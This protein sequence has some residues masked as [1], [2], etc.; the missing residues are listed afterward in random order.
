MK[1]IP[2]I[3]D[4]TNSNLIRNLN[5][6]KINYANTRCKFL[7]YFM[8]QNSEA[9]GEILINFIKLILKFCMPENIKS[10]WLGNINNKLQK[11]FDGKANFMQV[12]SWW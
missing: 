6:E 7:Y 8:I 2:H 3:I 12:G 5:I 1:L 9:L 11:L 4:Q 10:D